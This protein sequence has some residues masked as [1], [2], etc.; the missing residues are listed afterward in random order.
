MKTMKNSRTETRQLRLPVEG[1]TCA[2]CVSHVE[3]ALKGVPGVS[4]VQVNLATEKALLELSPGG[5]SLQEMVRSVDDA[6]YTIPM[7]RADLTIGGMTC[8]SCVAHVEGA[9]NGV[10]G[11][12]SV[13]VNLATERAAV[14]YIQ[15]TAS[16]RD[17]QQAVEGA[18]YTVEGPAEAGHGGE[19]ELERL[20]RAGEIWA[21]RNKFALAASLGAVIFLGSFDWF[22]WVSGL[23]DRTFYPFLLWALATPVQCWAG[24]AFYTSG[25]G[26]L[27]HR[28]ANM[29]TLIAL[30][31]SVAYLYSVAAIFLLTFAPGVLAVQQADGGGV[32]FDTAAIII[33]L[34]L[35]GRFLEARARGQTSEAIRRLME[36]EPATATVIRDGQEAEVPVELVVPGDMILV[37]SGERV[38]VDGEVVDG[39]SAVDE[40]MLTG[41][42]VPV[43][44]TQGAQVYG[45][46]IN[47]TGAFRFLAT[48][49]G[50]DTFLA[51]IIKLVEEAQ[52]S[53]APIQ[54]LADV[55]SAY[56]VP[57]VLAL[58]GA[59]F[60]FWVFLG[61]S[62]ALTHAF[63]VMVAVLIIACPCALGLATPTAVMVGT[64]KG[65]ERGVLIRTAGALEIAHKTNVVVLDKT[66]TLTTG[67]PSVTDL[68]PASV[69]E[70]QLLKTAASVEHSSEHPI[71]QAIVRL[72]RER[73]VA[74][75][76]VNGFEAIPGQGVRAAMNGSTVL[77]GNRAMMEAQGVA[78]NGLKPRAEELAGE[79][80]TA[81]YV[82]V[83][84]NALGVVAVGDSL[85][86]EAAEVVSR[87]RD[88]GVEV[89][90]ATG[91]TRAAADAVAARVGI[92]KVFAGI[93]PQDKTAVI[94][95]LQRE[96]KVVAM[97][98]DGINDAPA[99]SQ[100][101]IG[102]AIGT[103]TDV[104]MESADITL[105]RGDLNGVLT[106]ISLS[107]STIRTIKQNLF[108]AFFYNTALIPV[109]AGVLYPLFDHLGGVPSGLE[110]FF[111]ELGFLNPMLAALAMAF[112]SVTVV[113]NS[114]RLKRLKLA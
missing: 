14:E 97:V 39:F 21:L 43:E 100:A 46:T 84:A 86:A 57:A 24:W 70:E 51:Q 55:V 83:G 77:V 85:K 35:L 98:G 18:G 44:K 54:R 111:G 89:I 5:A 113:S 34:V 114:L 110:F 42:A 101:H 8:A 26:A 91:D 63:L 52:G 60:I 13:N 67:R 69:S 9:L 68:V 36:M 74:L 27:R 90:L 105:M 92:H 99:L 37:R 19:A 78:L 33:A 6:G 50:K 56:F 10:E 2:S 29:H 88:M 79:G 81:M 58:A 112:S 75:E 61:P 23:M 38:P 106:A 28:T 30:G 31:T 48:K 12:L 103:G 94:K 49:V 76:E 95:D 25:F 73:D 53:K 80:K 109:A 102:I 65:A 20:G 40:S 82:A 32:Y 3:G 15:G 4:S 62:P 66:G 72:A 7:E 1:M 47:K 93:M 108:W 45:A 71:A 104:A 16:L 87:L 11:V 41:E 107:R 22:P 64:G 17:F 96:G 59:A